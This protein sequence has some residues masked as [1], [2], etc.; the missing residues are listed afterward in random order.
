MYFLPIKIWRS[1]K[2]GLR[3]ETIFLSIPTFPCS[4]LFIYFY[5]PSYLYLLSYLYLSICRS[6]YNT[7]LSIYLSIYLSIIYLS[8]YL[9]IYIYIY[10]LRFEDGFR[11]MWVNN[12]NNLSK[13]YAGTGA[14]N[15]VLLYKKVLE[16]WPF[17]Y[18]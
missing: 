17:F 3:I 14:L 8:I 4:Y 16:A 11:Q 5:L 2:C 12:G 9:S 1:D 10:L 7:H 6:F 15:Q 13:I 18:V